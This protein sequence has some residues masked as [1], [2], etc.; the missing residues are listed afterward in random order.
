MQA[1]RKIGTHNGAF[2]V[3]EVLACAMLTKFT[4]AF[5]NGAITR[6]RDPELWRQ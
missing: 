2:H 1:I 6:T 3:D 5:Q 4:A